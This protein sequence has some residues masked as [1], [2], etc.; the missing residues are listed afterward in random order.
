VYAGRTY[1]VNQV[2]K[3]LAERFNRFKVAE[4]TLHREQEILSAKQSAL[5]ANRRKLEGML[6]ARKDLEVEIERLEARHR[7][8]QAAEAVSELEIDDSALQRAR[9]LIADLNKELDVR[10]RVL[11]SEG[12]FT[13]L[14]PVEAGS[15]ETPAD[16]ADQVARYFGRTSSS[17]EPVQ[18]AELEASVVSREAEVQE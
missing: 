5:D 7:S 14:I 13:G 1:T 18:P 17:V 4:E 15:T 9:T 3:D 2:E 6:S 8:V 16:I 11:D 12:K 10:E